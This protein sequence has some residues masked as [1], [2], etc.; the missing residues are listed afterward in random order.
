MF[1]WFIV[2]CVFIFVLLLLCDLLAT[3][4]IDLGML[5]ALYLFFCAAI[6]AAISATRPRADVAYSIQTL[7]RRL[8]KT[9][10]WAVC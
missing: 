1:V 6:F 2:M 4:M 5:C 10:N 7:A 9:H 8:S 3:K